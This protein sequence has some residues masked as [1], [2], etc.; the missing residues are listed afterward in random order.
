[1]AAFVLACHSYMKESKTYGFYA[2]ESATIHMASG[3]RKKVRNVIIGCSLAYVGSTFRVADGILSLGYGGHSFL[4]RALEQFNFKFSYCLVDHYSSRFAKGYL[5]FGA[6]PPSNISMTYA[7]LYANEVIRPYY[8]VDVMGISVD[9][10][11]LDIPPIVWDLRSMGG[12]ILD[13]G[14]TLT[15]LPEQ[16]Y[17]PLMNALMEGLKGFERVKFAPFEFC[18]STKKGFTD[19]M[20]PKMV[21]H[22]GESVRFE[23]PVKNYLIEVEDTETRCAGLMPLDWPNE[24]L[25]GN[26]MQQGHHWEFD[27]MNGVLGFRPSP[28]V[29]T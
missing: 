6:T 16:A 8:Y 11:M 23:P 1:M 7:T 20:A 21:W 19:D 2:N 10:V 3:K 4:D 25:I 29:S 12:A 22:W 24:T 18:F 9:G 17:R 28:C 15:Y 14:S 13:C 26:I 5:S 27:Y